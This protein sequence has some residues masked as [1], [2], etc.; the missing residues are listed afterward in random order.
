MNAVQVAEKRIN[1]GISKIF[2]VKDYPAFLS[3]ASNF[4]SF[5]YKN[6]ILI[7]LQDPKAKFVAGINAWKKITELGIKKTAV[8]IL[9]LYPDLSDGKVEYTIQKVFDFRQVDNEYMLEELIKKEHIIKCEKKNLFEGLENYLNNNDFSVYLGNNLKD[10]VKVDND[11]ITY[12]EDLTLDERISKIIDVYLRKQLTDFSEIVTGSIV[13]SSIYM[14]GKYYD[15]DVSRLKFT[16]IGL[17]VLKDEEKKLII[18][19]SCFFSKS[20]IESINS[21]QIEKI[22]TIPDKER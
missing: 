22:K 11:I 12:G 18:E 8:P 19:K 7:Y 9:V 4:L 17:P 15:I 1:D 21:Y 6:I 14:I 13:N 20:I 5:S 16:Y 10:S 3:F 2:T